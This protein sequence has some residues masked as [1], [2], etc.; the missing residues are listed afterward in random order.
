MQSI[1]F[2]VPG[3]PQGKARP[4]FRRCGGFVRTYTPA[5]TQEYE[6]SVS[7]A[8][9]RST[10]YRWLRGTP[11]WLTVEAR[12]PIPASASKKRRAELLGAPHVSRPDS[13]NVV[14]AVCD[15]LNGLA[16]E[17]DSQVCCLSVRKVY[18]AEPGLTVAV[19]EETDDED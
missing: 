5:R 1:R 11:L 16:W 19:G 7:S 14:K 4:R 2:E 3:T 10:S 13:D 6:E 8:Y 12:F 15:A 17:D 18:A 9:R